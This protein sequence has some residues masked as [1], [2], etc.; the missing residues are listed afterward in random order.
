MQVSKIEE[1][2]MNEI[3]Q[4]NGGG[5][6]GVKG[7][8]SFGLALGIGTVTFGAGWGS[9]GVGL[10]FASAPLA[11]G[12]MVALALYGGYQAAK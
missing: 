2:T 10:A 9:V 12:A 5:P 4:V 7:A 11:V 3:E 1:L 6:R 8:A